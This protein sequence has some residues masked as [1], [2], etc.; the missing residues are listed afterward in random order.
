[1]QASLWGAQ[2][3]ESPSYADKRSKTTNKWSTW[4]QRW[5]KE[6]SALGEELRYGEESEW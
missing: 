3:Y 1:M 4:H 5:N 2:V 6:Q